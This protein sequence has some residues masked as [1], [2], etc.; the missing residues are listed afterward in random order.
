MSTII[1]D[2]MELISNTPAEVV[3]NRTKSRFYMMLSKHIEKQGVGIKEV[4]EKYN[5][6]HTKCDI[7]ELHWTRISLE[8][9]IEVL[10]DAG[11]DVG[12]S[13]EIDPETGLNSAT[14]VV[15]LPK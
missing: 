9:W 15:N 1:K 11:L 14:L 12:H 8:K 6:P 2:P 3:I 13:C 7:I 10:V 5:L 4:A